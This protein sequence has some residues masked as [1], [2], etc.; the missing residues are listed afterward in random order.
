MN[1]YEISY[2][3]SKKV[4]YKVNPN[5]IEEEIRLENETLPTHVLANNLVEAFEK[6]AYNK[7]KYTELKEVNIISENVNLF[8]GENK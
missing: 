6:L 3:L 2:A 8:N 4:N 7:L 5:S 1:L